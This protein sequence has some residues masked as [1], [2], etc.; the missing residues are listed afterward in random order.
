MV[1][2]FTNLCQAVWSEDQ[3]I[4][5]CPAQDKFPAGIEGEVIYERADLH[6]KALYPVGIAQRQMQTCQAQEKIAARFGYH[7]ISAPDF[8]QAVQQLPVSPG[9]DGEKRYLPGIGVCPQDA[10]EFH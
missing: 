10:A 6:E 4:A 9:K 5:I 8:L 7:D 2:D 3:P 1:R